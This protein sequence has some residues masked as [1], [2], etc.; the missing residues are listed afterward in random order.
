M[1]GHLVTSSVRAT[2]WKWSWHWTARVILSHIFMQQKDNTSLDIHTDIPANFCCLPRTTPAAVTC[3]EPRAM[4]SGVKKNLLSWL[5]IVH[6]H[7]QEK[8][9]MA[10]NI[11]PWSSDQEEETWPFFAL[12]GFGTASSGG[13]LASGCTIVSTAWELSSYR[14]CNP[15]LELCLY[16]RSHVLRDSQSLWQTKIFSLFWRVRRLQS[17]AKLRSLLTVWRRKLREKAARVDLWLKTEDHRNHS[18]ALWREIEGKCWGMQV[19]EIL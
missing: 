18:A 17:N 6:I 12:G 16:H 8:T 5:T 14:L 13:G 10:R 1:Q 19:C 11:G 9:C 3:P 2:S 15:S 4:H 7:L